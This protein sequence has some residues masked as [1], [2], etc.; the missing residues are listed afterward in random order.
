MSNGD[1]GSYLFHQGTNFRAYEYLGC[2]LE[3][4]DGKYEYTFRTWA[5]NAKSVGLVS[6]FSGWYRAV[7][8]SRVTDNGIWE[9]KYLSD[10]SLELQPYKFRV[11]SK[12]GSHD[13]GDPYARFSR[14]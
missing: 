12:K 1:L 13:K 9:L 10:V 3:M 7:P 4:K 2:S 14:G 6:D 5:P 11:R 8:F